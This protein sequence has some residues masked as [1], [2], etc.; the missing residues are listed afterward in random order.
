[1]TRWLTNRGIPEK[2]LVPNNEFGEAYETKVSGVGTVKE[3]PTCKRAGP[4]DA[5]WLGDGNKW[6]NIAIICGK[7]CGIFWGLANLPPD[8]LV[9]IVKE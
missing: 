4:I 5:L 7:P 9:E 3:C 1:M 8:D 2:V 6:P